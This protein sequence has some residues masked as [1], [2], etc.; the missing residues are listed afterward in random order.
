[1]ENYKNYTLIEAIIERK[2]RTSASLSLYFTTKYI[3][4]SITFTFPVLPLSSQECC[5]KVVRN[6]RGWATSGPAIR[7]FSG[8]IP[9]QQ[10]AAI[11]T[12]PGKIRLW[13]T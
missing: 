6:A 13:T 3:K 12:I 4:N 8:S 7:K 1:V 2:N 9:T 10:T 11:A 5:D